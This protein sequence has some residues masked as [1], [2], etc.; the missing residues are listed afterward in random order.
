MPGNE[1]LENHRQAF[2]QPPT[3]VMLLHA[4]GLLEARLN[5]FGM[6]FARSFG[7]SLSLSLS[8]EEGRSTFAVV[9]GIWA[10]FY[11]ITKGK[12]NRH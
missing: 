12:W 9:A 7:C 10:K 5:D 1:W 8:V 2:V 11:G 6:W 3:V 4:Q